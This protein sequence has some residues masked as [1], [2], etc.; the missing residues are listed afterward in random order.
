MVFGCLLTTMQL[1]DFVS[2]TTK[3]SVVNRVSAAADNAAKTATPV[4][5]TSVFILFPAANK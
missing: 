5:I 1:F 4:D 3:Y 2:I